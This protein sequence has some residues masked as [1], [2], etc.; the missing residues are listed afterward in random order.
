MTPGELL[1]A[2]DVALYRAKD[3]GGGRRRLRSGDG[4]RSARALRAGARPPR[5]LE[6]GAGAWRT[7]PWWT[8]QPRVRA[9]EALARWDH[10]SAG[11]PAGGL[12]AARGGNGADRAHGAWVLEQACREAARWA[13]RDR[14][15]PVVSVNV[16]RA[17]PPRV[18][19]ARGPDPGHGA[20]SRR[21]QLEVSEQVLVE[22]LR[23][24][25]ATLRD[26]HALGLE[27]AID[28]FGSG[29]SSLGYFRELN[30]H[31]LKVDRSSCSGWPLTRA[32]GRSCGRS[33]TWLTPTACT[34]QSRASRRP[35]RRPSCASSA[36]I[37]RRDSGPPSPRRQRGCALVADSASDC[38]EPQSF[39]AAPVTAS[40]GARGALYLA[41]S[42]S[43]RPALVDRAVLGR[44]RTAVACTGLA[45]GPAAEGRLDQCQ[46]PLWTRIRRARGFPR[47]RRCRTAGMLDR[48]ALCARRGRRHRPRRFRPFLTQSTAPSPWRA[49][50]SFRG[51]WR[52]SP[53]Q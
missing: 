46:C 3:A 50:V 5:R 52:G 33:P 30:A 9:V 18:R 49:S 15:A 40:S 32:S 11:R 31:A 36:G 16:G 35:N 37:G 38:S 53:E 7:S 2:A 26:L 17:V 14:R 25:S 10:P 21:L 22:E 13:M 51:P 20:G 6:A 39:R 42:P 19:R 48:S 24:T 12:R 4:G 27:L 45:V 41:A 1:K 47:T 29:A 44:R 43:R 34:S 8:W 28:D 23:A